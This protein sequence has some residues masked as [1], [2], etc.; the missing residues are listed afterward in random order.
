MPNCWR[1]TS[2]SRKSLFSSICT[3]ISCALRWLIPLT[4]ASRSGSSSIIRK[5]SSPNC[6]TILAARE[7]PTPLMAPEPRYR[8]M[9]RLSFGTTTWK[10]AIFSWVP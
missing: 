4:S 9:P 3:A 8:S 2:A 6:R 1:Y 10:L 7:G 5:V